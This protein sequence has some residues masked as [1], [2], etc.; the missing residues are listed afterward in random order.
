MKENTGFP[1]EIFVLV[2]QVFAAPFM[3]GA[4]DLGKDKK[5]IVRCFGFAF[6]LHICCMCVSLLCLITACLHS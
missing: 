6:P 4:A 5:K 1:L 3:A 2:P